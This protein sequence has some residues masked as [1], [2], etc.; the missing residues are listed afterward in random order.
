MAWD[1]VLWDEGGWD[2]VGWD[3]L[4]CTAIRCEAHRGAYDAH[5]LHLTDDQITVLRRIRYLNVT[6]VTARYLNASGEEVEWNADESGYLS[7]LN[8]IAWYRYLM[9]TPSIA[10]VA[11]PP[12][13]VTAESP[14]D[15]DV[16]KPP[17][18]EEV[19]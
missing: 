3:E 7:Y 16:A 4:S 2:E 5:V 12:A 1:A 15:A 14:A 17:A 10:E 8:P 19:V 9:G 18:P 11:T 6:T 13:E